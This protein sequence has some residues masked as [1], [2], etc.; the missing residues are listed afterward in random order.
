M[1]G[2]GSYRRLGSSPESS[3]GVPHKIDTSNRLR[4]NLYIEVTRNLLSTGV[5]IYYKFSKIGGY[6]K[7]YFRVLRHRMAF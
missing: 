5:N 2:I 1:Q 3:R 7:A 6:S 4:R